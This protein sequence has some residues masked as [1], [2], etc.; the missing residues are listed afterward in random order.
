MTVTRKG[1]AGSATV[2][3]IAAIVGTSALGVALVAVAVLVGTRIGLNTAA[4]AAALAAVGAAIEHRS[5]V[6]AARMFA[7]RN[8][9]DLVRCECPQ[10]EGA[11]FVVT[12]EVAADV[13]VP[14]LGSRTIVARRSAE[15]EVE[16]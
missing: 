16:P 12:V 1:E 14:L 4:D 3:A 8:G 13:V 10:Y 7:D 15:Y 11:S 5:P 6:E 9:A 2:A